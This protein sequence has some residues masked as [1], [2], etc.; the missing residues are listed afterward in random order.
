MHRWHI[1]APVVIFTAS[2]CAGPRYVAPSHASS[3]HRNRRVLPRDCPRGSFA[4]RS[5]SDRSMRVPVVIDAYRTLNRI[6]GAS[7]VRAVP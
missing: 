5:A 1:H 2:G 3:G 6:N 7:K 4:S